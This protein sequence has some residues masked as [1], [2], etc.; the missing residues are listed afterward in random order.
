MEKQHHVRRAPVAD[1]VPLR[2][3][4]S[5]MFRSRKIFSWSLLLVLVTCGLTWVGY[6][7]TIDFMDDLT[8]SFMAAAPDSSTT[9]GW[10]KHKGWVAGSWMYH[11]ILRILA[12]YLAFLLAYTLTTPGY[13]F[14]SAAAEKIH[15]GEHF[16]PDAA[17]TLS[18]ILIDIFEGAKIAVFGII[19]T[20]FALFLNFIPVIGQAAVFLIYTYYSALMF[21]DYP[22]SRRRWGLREK[23]VWMRNSSSPSF[24][25][26]VFPAL[27]SMV[28]VLNIFAMALLFP[29]MTV[30]ATLNFSAI[31][32]AKKTPSQVNPV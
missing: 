17:F 25:I 15:A 8:G 23:L 28:P 30:H 3:S 13:A 2:D 9:W 32:L 10:V 29:V 21:I 11:F 19:I 18:G 6:L 20:F 24:R 5:L 14:L 31:E 16:D 27:I 12:F 7:L 1:W 26:G 22:A 4:L